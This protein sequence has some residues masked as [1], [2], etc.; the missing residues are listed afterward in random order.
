MLLS[1]ENEIPD[2]TSDSTPESLTI[3]VKCPSG[4]AVSCNIEST[5]SLGKDLFE[6]VEEMTGVPTNMQLLSY[7]AQLIRPNIKLQDYCLKDGC[8]VHLSVK[9]IGGNGNS[10]TGILNNKLN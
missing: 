3:M 8:C 7:R 10:D 9:G 6:K 2:L 1:S 5:E 4:E